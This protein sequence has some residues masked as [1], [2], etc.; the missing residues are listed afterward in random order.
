M[1]PPITEGWR[2]TKPA[3]SGKRGVVVSQCRAGA[4]AGIA[5]LEAG[6]NAVDAAVGTAMALA[7]QEPWN[8]GLGGYGGFAVVHRAGEARAE[9]VDFGPVS[10]RGLTTEAFKLT[11]RMTETG[12]RWPEVQGTRTS[13]GRWRSRCRR[14]WRG[15]RRCTRA[16]GGCRWPR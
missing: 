16:G 7:S 12:F 9:V 10:P 4:E 5:I 8:S 15:A 2:L 1:I 13:T 3:A 6:G 14:R 11:G